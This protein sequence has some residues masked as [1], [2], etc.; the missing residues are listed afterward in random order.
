MFFKIFL[1]IILLNMIINVI[2]SSSCNRKVCTKAPGNG[3]QCFVGCGTGHDIKDCAMKCPAGYIC[4]YA[5]N[6]NTCENVPCPSG[7]NNWFCPKNFKC[8]NGI[9]LQK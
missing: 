3:E 7:Q 9:C 2:D 1:S 8:S 5:P 4:N 6:T